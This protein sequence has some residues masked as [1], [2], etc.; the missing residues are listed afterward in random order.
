MKVHAADVSFAYGRREVLR[1]LDCEFPEGRITAIVGA[2]ASGKSTLLRTMARLVKPQQGAVLLDGID[3]ATLPTRGVARQVGFLPQSPIAPEGLTVGDLVARGRYPHQRLGRPQSAVDRERIAWALDATGTAELR[4]RP[5]DQLS[6]GQ[7]QRVWI[8]MVLAQDTEVLLLDEPTTYLDLAHQ[9]EVLDLL[10]EL[11]ERDGRTIVLVLHDLNQACRY[12]H[13]LVAMRDG[14]IY[15]AGDPREIV[16]AELV[17][18][19]LNLRAEILDDPVSGQPLCIPLMREA[20]ADRPAPPLAV[21]TAS[22][23]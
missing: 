21:R 18:A 8:A 10:A 22:S 2:N 11:N 23:S 12:A 6:G 14:V 3:I 19:V 5:L 13:H 1:G 4:D 17:Y 20:R 9:L 15:A 7:R 16:D